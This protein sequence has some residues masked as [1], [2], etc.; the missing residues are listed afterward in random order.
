MELRANRILLIVA[1]AGP[2]LLM[3]LLACTPGISFM[4][5][6]GRHLLLGRI[7]L[8]RHV[9]PDTNF[10]TYTH[11]DFPFV[12]HHWLSEV[13]LYLLHKA[14]GLNGL[15]IWKMFMMTAALG[16]AL[17][18]IRPQRDYGLYWIAGIL[19]AVMM[20]FRAHIRPELFT[21]L[22]VALYLWFFEHIRQG[23]KWPRWV[24]LLIAC[25]WANAH[26]YFIFGI[27]MIG[28]FAWETWRRDRSRTALA[29]E[30]AWLGAVILVSCINPNGAK[31]LL[32]PLA[33][34]T[35]YGIGIT[36][37][38]SP[39]ACWQSVLN[40]ML[41]ALPFMSGLVLWAVWAGR[42]DSR[43]ANSIIALVALLATWKMARSAPLLALTGLPLIV[44]ALGS[45]SRFRVSSFK[46]PILPLVALI[47]NAW[48]ISGVVSG[49]YSRVF[50]SPIPP[51]PFGF[52]REERFSRLTA[53]AQNGLQGPIFT[54]Y[55]IGSLVEYELYPE[56][57]Y[58]DNRPE[59][60]PASFWRAEYLPALALT[61]RWTQVCEARKIQ[62]VIVSLAGVKEA[63][64]QELMRRPEWALVHL[65]EICA[66]F[67]RNSPD[68][69]TFL[70]S[71]AFAPQRLAEYRKG[72]EDELAVLPKSP[73][74]RRQVDA[75]VLVYKLYGL[76]CIGHADLAWPCLKQ[77]YELY[78]DYQVVH[79]LMRVT[80]PQNEFPMMERIL[81]RRARWPLAAKQ[82]LDWSRRLQQT[83][84]S[85]EAENVL[86]RGHW[87]F[88][89]SPAIRDSL[90]EI[91]DEGYK[92]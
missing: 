86:K 84:R 79:E 51:T 50:P 6:L 10:L 20:S 40:P 65:D 59:A 64:I 89:L 32:Y 15:I 37:N 14:G 9:V 39:L 12:N 44:G 38:M 47:L 25:F 77:L 16:I 82:V 36:E 49:W 83:G 27:G 48:L 78:P 13:M 57:G 75:D 2:L 19:A 87:F 71:H 80:A 72:I 3:I 54:D 29:R 73:L 69:E 67:V 56:P 61:G 18:A 52:D 66:V 63:Y 21:Y 33:I 7:I 53:L 74:G 46:L 26:I 17:C 92:I 4:E 5:D 85:E 43:P 60:F 41:I 58:C 55:N 1:V 45:S 24:I 68:H 62:A 28:T 30:L 34:F 81:A 88:P 70:R 76:L 22:F 42:G 90:N 31:G 11:P 8:E 91:A 35:N 23:A